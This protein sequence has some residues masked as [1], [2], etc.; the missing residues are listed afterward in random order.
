M[1][2]LTDL[3]DQAQVLPPDQREQL[4]LMLLDSLPDD[5][6]LPIVLDPEYEA[7]LE[8]RI[9]EIRTGRAKTHDWESVRES[10]RVTLENRPA[11]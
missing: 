11:Q 1:N 10:L 9:E 2:M 6:D 3:F 7:E 5:Q 8:R 4:A